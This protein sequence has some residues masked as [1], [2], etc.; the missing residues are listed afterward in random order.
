[1]G[2]AEALEDTAREVLLVAVREVDHDDSTAF[3]ELLLEET[4]ILLGNADQVSQISELCRE[5]A[6][7]CPRWRSREHPG[8]G[9]GDNTGPDTRYDQ[10]GC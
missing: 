3:A 2:H 7:H 8:N 1:L 9:S 5:A 6:H 10:T 4:L